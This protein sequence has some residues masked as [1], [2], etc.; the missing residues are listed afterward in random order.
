MTKQNLYLIRHGETPWTLSRQHTGRTDIS[1]TEKGQKQVHLLKKRLQSIPFHTVFCS[2]LKRAQETCALTEI[3]HPMISTPELAEWDYGDYEGKT[4][5]QIR[6]TDPKWNLFTDGSPNGEQPKDIEK[7]LHHFFKQ[8]ESIEG[9][10]AIF[11]H[12][13][14]L[15]SLTA[16]WLGL[17]IRQAS[18]FFL[19]TASLSHLGYE[20]EHRALYLWNDTSH[21]I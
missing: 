9:N 17:P 5:L 6:E 21:L 12:G 19:A 10:I 16:L 1:L 7:R 2:P 18:L 8:I 13:H 14:L 3:K 15:R 4:T 11:S 20:R